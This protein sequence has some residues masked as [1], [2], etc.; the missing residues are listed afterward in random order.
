MTP[1][2]F[3]REIVI[4]TLEDFR[5]DRTSRRWAYLSAIVVYHLRD[6][7]A[8]AL[9]TLTGEPKVDRR[10]VQAELARVD[11]AVRAALPSP[12]AFDV[13]D[14]VAIGSK[15]A[16]TRSSRGVT[17]A[18][19]SDW[20]RPPAFADVMICDLS[21]L[22]DETGGVKIPH[23]DVSFD[24]YDAVQSTFLAFL[25]AFPT[26]LVGCSFDGPVAICCVGCRSGSRL[27]TF[28]LC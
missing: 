26:Q 12:E 1:A 8:E 24:V 10:A 19:G 4:P 11:E 2:D 27:F 9:A 6:Y 28:T 20:E 14:A 3:A 21:I 16:L 7:L 22:D 25:A 15:H 5:A 17:F 13:V 18:A 23:G